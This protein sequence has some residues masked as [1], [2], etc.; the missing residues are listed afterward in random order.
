M[1]RKTNNI[2]YIY[3]TTCNVTGKWYIG[4]HSTTKLN[5]GYLGSGTILRHS[6]RKHGKKNHTKEI[7]EFCETRELL[8]LREAEIIN[9]E[10]LSDGKCM[11]LKEGG[12]GGFISE[13]H[14]LNCSKAG[15]EAFK[16]KLLNDKEFRDNFSITKSKNSIN[17]ILNGKIKKIEYDWTNKKHSE[18]TKQLMSKIKKGVG[19]GETNSQYGTC[20]VTKDDVNKKIKKE[21]LETYLN[22]GWVRGRK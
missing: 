21:E 5:D 19:I 7:L 14:M 18:E 4:M 16:S 17:A 3:K 8:A 2:H 6:I 15:N 22:E 1:A 11:N 13:E 12:D 9:K 20:W 10:L